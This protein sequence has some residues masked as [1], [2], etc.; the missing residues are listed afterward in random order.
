MSEMNEIEI[1]ERFVQ[2]LKKSSSAAEMMSKVNKYKKWSEVGQGLRSFLYKGQQLY[3]SS[4][5]KGMELERMVNKWESKLKA[6]TEKEI[7]Q[8]PTRH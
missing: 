4:K 1:L 7:G 3:H 2:G 8:Q 5:P 6:E